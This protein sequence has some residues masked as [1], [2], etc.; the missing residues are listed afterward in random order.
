M[1]GTMDWT[2]MIAAETDVGAYLPGTGTAEIP[3]GAVLKGG[4]AGAWDMDW[5]WGSEMVP[6]EFPQFKVVVES[7]GGDD[8]RV[9]L[10]PSGVRDADSYKIYFEWSDTNPTGGDLGGYVFLDGAEI[11][12]TAVRTIRG[13]NVYAKNNKPDQETGAPIVDHSAYP[14]WYAEYGWDVPDAGADWSN[15]TRYLL[16]LDTYQKKWWLFYID[17]PYPSTKGT[18]DLYVQMSGD[19]KKVTFNDDGTI[20]IDLKEKGG[21]WKIFWSWGMEDVDLDGKNFLLHLNPV[22]KTGYIVPKKLLK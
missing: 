10:T 7:L 6:L 12:M 17:Y 22:D 18:C 2:T 19:T 13:F 14:S 21:D 15:G 5:S 4:G 9:S 16:S 1:S 3:G 11:C 8:Y 20:D